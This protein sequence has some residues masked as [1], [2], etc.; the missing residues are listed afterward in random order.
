MKIINH[1][2]NGLQI[3]Q[4]AEDGYV[5]ATD[6]C[7]VANR[8]WNNYWRQKETQEYLLALAKELG[9][10]VIVK[11]PVTLIRA[12]ALIQII[13]GGNSQQGTWVHPEVATDLAQW[14]SV[15]F[16]IRVNRWIVRWMTAG[17]NP[18][19][20]DSTPTD[21]IAEIE[22]L[23]NLIISIRSQSRIFHTGSHQPADDALVKSL[24]T[25]S[26]NQLSIINSAIERLQKLKQVAEMNFELESDADL[27]LPISKPKSN[28]QSSANPT[29][30]NITA[31]NFIDSIP[32]VTKEAT[33][34]FTVDLPESMYRDL[35]ILAAETGKTKADIVRTLLGKALRDDV[36]E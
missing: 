1:K 30:N 4:R 15:L 36:K 12:T 23:E 27:E 21:L 31:A 14:V 22:H 13:Q 16:R 5:N 25:I 35:S 8:R 9:L 19:T 28:N 26:H 33:V 34:R 18:I 10:T 2:F 11:N 7:K 17:K 6:M 20:A 24:H 32:V 29:M 3:R